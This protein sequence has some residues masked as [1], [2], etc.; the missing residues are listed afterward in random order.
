MIKHC[1]EW[2]VSLIYPK[3]CEICSQLISCDMDLCDNC[4]NIIKP[5]FK[6]RKLEY[7]PRKFSLC[8]SLFNYSGLIREAVCKFKF[9]GG[10][11]LSKYFVHNVS[12]KSIKNLIKCEIDYITCVPLS[13]KR[14]KSRGYN[15]AECFARD[16]SK[17]INIPYK[18][19]LDKI[20]D[21]PPQHEL[22]AD[23]RVQNVCGIYKILNGSDIKGK[24]ILLCDDIITTGSTMKECIKTLKINGAN[25]VFCCTIASA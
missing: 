25:K 17:K 3:K 18:D 1:I 2:I 16:L 14:R 8:I 22:S 5:I 21:N 6:I 10:R 19:L 15:Q 12:Y 13:N 4:K 20:L 23:Q 7:I 9:H 11:E 24:N